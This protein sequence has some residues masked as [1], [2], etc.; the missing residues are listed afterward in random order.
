MGNDK[1][2]KGQ[3]LVETAFILI[4]LMLIVLGIAEFARAWFM[5]SS[6]KN[7]VRHGV[8][9]AVVTP[10]ITNGGT[11]TKPDPPPSTCPPSLTGNEK[12]F[13]EIWKASPGVP[14]G[15]GTSVTLAV[16]GGTLE[17]GDEIKVTATVTN[18]QTIVPKLLGSFIPSTLSA[19]ASMRYE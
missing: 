16:E 14:V 12:V 11:A 8:R 15:A 13:C 4:L 19:E 5:K 3:T 10:D 17:T 18:F 1:K 7:A 6:L 2:A 9:V